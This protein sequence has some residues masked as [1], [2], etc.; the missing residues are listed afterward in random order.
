M[1]LWLLSGGTYWV[2]VV[3]TLIYGSGYGGFI[4]LSPAVAASKFGLKGL[5]GV[6]GTW[7]SAAA[8]GSFGGPPIAGWIIDAVSYEAAIIFAGAAALLGWA[9]LIRLDD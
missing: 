4:A 3:F 2:L 8:F 1:G 6:L 7:Y 5:G 9:L